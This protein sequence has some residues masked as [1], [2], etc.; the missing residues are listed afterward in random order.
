M[1]LND[2]ALMGLLSNN[3][4]GISYKTSSVVVKERKDFMKDLLF[5]Y[6]NMDNVILTNGNNDEAIG[7]SKTIRFYW[8]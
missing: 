1:T 4:K 6:N 7:M 3:V 8:L 2:A 5:I